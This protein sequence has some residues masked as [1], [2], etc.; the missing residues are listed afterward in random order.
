MIRLSRSVAVWVPRSR[1][2][3]RSAVARPRCGGEASGF[4]V[5]DSDRSH[6][7]SRWD[8]NRLVRLPLAPAPHGHAVGSYNILRAFC[9]SD[10]DGKHLHQAPQTVCSERCS[11][12]PWAT[13]RASST[14]WGRASSSTAATTA[15]TRSRSARSRS[16]SPG[17]ARP[18]ALD[19]RVIGSPPR[20]RIRLHRRC[21]RAGEDLQRPVRRR[22]RRGRRHEAQQHRTEPLTRRDAGRLHAHPRQRRGTSPR[23][24]PPRPTAATCSGW[25]GAATNPLWSPAGNRIAYL[26]PPGR[27]GRRGGSWRRRAVRARRSCATAP[28]P[29]SAGPRT[30]AGSPSRTRRGGSPSSTSRRRRCGGC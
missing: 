20:L 11:N 7:V 16:S 4:A 25:S 5:R 2:R 21:S 12:N 1:S 9:V 8:S 3:W 30:A 24:G 13:R 19:A 6:L 28:A 26:A 14:G 22:R 29:S 15:S 27:L 23:S 17:R 10:A 18:Y